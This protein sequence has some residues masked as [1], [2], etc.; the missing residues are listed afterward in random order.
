M[1]LASV[2]AFVSCRRPRVLVP[3]A[4]HMHGK[5][6]L[7]NRGLAGLP[8]RLGPGNASTS[9]S[10]CMWP[11]AMPKVDTKSQADGQKASLS[12]SAE[13]IPAPPSLGSAPRWPPRD[14]PPQRLGR[15]APPR[16]YLTTRRLAGA[17][18]LLRVYVLGWLVRRHRD[19]E[20]MPRPCGHPTLSPPSGSTPAC[21]RRSARVRLPTPNW[22]ERACV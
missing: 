22:A 2:F 18:T 21:L 6:T 10:G 7:R 5:C 20:A 19:V 1:G 14:N 4:I 8:R 12:G 13:N 3:P 11:C 15:A 17:A 9:P 16:S